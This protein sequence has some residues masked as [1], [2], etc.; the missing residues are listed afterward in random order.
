M[1]EIKQV[2]LS[3]VVNNKITYGKNDIVDEF[4]GLDGNYI[5]RD[6]L[7]RIWESAVGKF[8]I[9]NDG[10]YDNIE[11]DGQTL[12]IDQYIKKL[13]FLGF[14]FWGKNTERIIVEFEDGVKEIISVTFED[15]TVA[16]SDDKSIFKEYSD[17]KYNTL[18]ATTTKGNM[19]HIVNFHYTRCNLKHIAKVKNI[20]LPQNMFMHIFAITIEN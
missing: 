20:V 19:I 8:F 7:A 6:I 11:C 5:D 1:G 15:W 14:F 2:D 9:L 13:Y 16:S 18:F 3:N 4:S 17:G 12:Q 10:F